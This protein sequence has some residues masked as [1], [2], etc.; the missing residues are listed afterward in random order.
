MTSPDDHTLTSASLLPYGRRELHAW[1]GQSNDFGTDGS[2][3]VPGPIDHF[4][5]DAPDSGVLEVVAADHFDPPEYRLAPAGELQVLRDPV[6][7]D[8]DAGMGPRLSFGRARRA[9]RPDIARLAILPRALGES[10]LLNS[11][12][13]RNW[14]PGSVPFEALRDGLR[15][16][17]DTHPR[18]PLVSVIAGFGAS[19]PPGT[20]VAEWKAALGAFWDALQDLRGAERATL[21]L[22]AMPEVLRAE[23]ESRARIDLAQREFAEENARAVYVSTV[24]LETPEDDRSHFKADALRELGRR[25]AVALEP[26]VAL[27]RQA[28][29]VGRFPDQHLEFDAETGGFVD[30]HFGPARVYRPVLEDDPE[31]G[32]VLRCARRGFDTSL[33]LNDDAYTLGL[34]VKRMAD[35]RS[36]GDVDDL[37]VGGRVGSDA[38]GN[39][40]SRRFLAHA[41]PGVAPPMAH[42][43]AGAPGFLEVGRWVHVVATF[44]GGSGA[45]FADGVPVDVG[46]G[47]GAYPAADGPHIVQLGAWGAL[48][49]PGV[50][51]MRFDSITVL[52]RALSAAEVK[53]LHARTAHGGP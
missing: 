8:R 3:G 27:P 10:G 22:V 29:P 1:C 2:D 21:V 34:W 12:P 44:G 50:P 30:V 18:Y 46:L 4:G 23:S 32:R 13:A 37:L 41:E 52:P 6:G 39:L 7:D 47:G 17:Q 28:A 53:D 11:D 49:A 14:S 31:R 33:L 38:V 15:A 19:E 43:L 5:L 51:D 35:P 9:R 25:V 16:F 24:G 36:N 42:S 48:D 40:F 45:V 26:R 20:T